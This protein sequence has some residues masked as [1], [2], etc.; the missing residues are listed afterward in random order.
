M[1]QYSFVPAGAHAPPQQFRSRIMLT[2]E[3]TTAAPPA[4]AKKPATKKKQQSKNTKKQR[5]GQFDNK[6]LKSF[7]NTMEEVLPIGLREWEVVLERHNKEWSKKERE[8]RG[9]RQKFNRLNSSKLPTGDPNCPWDVKWAKQLKRRI[10][11]KADSNLLN[12]VSEAEDDDDPEATT[13]PMEDESET[14]P[15]DDD[16]EEE[17]E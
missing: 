13:T 5:G 6:E 17:G 14:P 9:L 16:D 12:D 7:F 4:A 10:D 2:N 15:G 11:E 1:S 3:S 8:V